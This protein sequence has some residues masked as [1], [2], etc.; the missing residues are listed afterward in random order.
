MKRLLLSLVMLGTMVPGSAQ[1]RYV[2]PVLHL[3][4]SDPDVCRV[5]DDYYLT[6]S[7]FNQIP[8]LPILHSRDLVRWE[9][10]GAA[11]PGIVR[12]HRTVRQTPPAH[13]KGVWAPSIRYHDGWFYIFYGDPDQGIFQIRT[14]HPA[15]RWEAPVPVVKGKGFIDPCPL[16][17]DA[18][19]AWLSTTRRLWKCRYGYG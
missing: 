19:R 10:I 14:Q 2:N 15:G 6:A 4:Y 11:L 3:D 13:G 5:G 7:S 17:D 12:W 18:G 9:R 8:G 1:S 16:W